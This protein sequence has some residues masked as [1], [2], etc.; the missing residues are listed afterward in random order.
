MCKF[1]LFNFGGDF[2]EVAI[3]KGFCRLINKFQMN[4]KELEDGQSR[5]SMHVVVTKLG[6]I[7][8]P[9]REEN[10]SSI[11]VCGLRQS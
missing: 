9:T 7:N 10:N 5:V 11:N 6:G 1:V 3:W 4:V 8:H 2:D